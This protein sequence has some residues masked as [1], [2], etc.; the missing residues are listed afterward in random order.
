MSA[1][2]GVRKMKLVQTIFCT[3]PQ[4]ARQWSAVLI[5][6]GL[7]WLVAISE[8]TGAPIL[9]DASENLRMALNL[10]RHGVISMDEGPPYRP[11]MWREPVPIAVLAV[12]IYTTDIVLG[13]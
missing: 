1:T 10:E 3:I 13:K 5:A 11:S 8:I 9:K 4:P 2:N 7:V 6:L 12:A